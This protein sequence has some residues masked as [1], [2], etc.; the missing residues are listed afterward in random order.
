MDSKFWY[1]I[2]GYVASGLVAISLT[3]SSILRLRII[4]LV[5]AIIFTIYGLLIGAYPIVIV[6]LIITLINIYY[7]FQIFGNREYFTMLVTHHDSDYLQSFLQFHA[8]EIKKFL[9]D[10]IYTPSEEQLIIFILRDMI[11]AGLFIAEQHP[12]GSLWVQLDFVIPG[13]RDFK[14]GQFIFEQK[15]DFLRQRG[16]QEIFSAPGTKPHAR[17]LLRMGFTPETPDNHNGAYTRTIR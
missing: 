12:D 3:M 9:P 4:N 13:Y 7:L 16:I 8:S 11:P 6:N 10:F 5:G 15:A 14:V 1:E 2:V 17:Y